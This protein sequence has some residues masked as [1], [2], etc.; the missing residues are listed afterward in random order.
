MSGDFLLGRIYQDGGWRVLAD[1]RRIA[2]VPDIPL[3]AARLPPGANRVVLLYRP[4]GFLAGC[5]L[6]ALALALGM[7]RWCPPPRMP[8]E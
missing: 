8:L 3:V 4:G 5:L 6:A 2:A 7:A 1:G